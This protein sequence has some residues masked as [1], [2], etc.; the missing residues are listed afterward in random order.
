MEDEGV[1]I[2]CESCK[3]EYNLRTDLGPE[4]VPEYCAFCGEF[5]DILMM[6]SEML[7]YDDDGEPQS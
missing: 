3:A 2:Y 5:I 6:Q 1:E 7:D 4:Y